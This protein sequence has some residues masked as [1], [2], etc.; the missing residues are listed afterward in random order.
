MKIAI[1]SVSDKG[2]VLAQCLLEKLKDDSTVM[3]VDHYH[4]NV[5]NVIRNVFNE[6]DAIIAVMASGIIIR[7]IAPFI[8]SKTS[9]P[10]ILNM[11][12]NG[13]FVVSML[14]GH[15]GGANKLTNKI[16]ELIGATP[17]ITTSTDVNNRLGI[18]TLAND[19]YFSIESYENILPINKAI[20]E[21]REVIFKLN[22]RSDFTFLYEYINNNTLEIDVFIKFSNEVP[23]DQINVIIDDKSLK[24][25]K[26]NLI[27]G[28]GCRRGKSKEEIE[29][30]ILDA[31]KTINL[32][33]NRVDQISSADVKK[34]EDG[35]LDLAESY[36][37]P[38]TFVESD[39]IKNFS[40]DDISESE[41]VKSKFG[42]GGVC[43]PSALLLAGE[44]SKLIYKKTAFN[45]VT[46][47]I[48]L[49]K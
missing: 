25:K 10:A 17:V 11:D 33:I 7:S 36:D 30:G 44:D 45:G 43:E 9:D 28:I 42:I 1:L 31:L 49:S 22:K 15:L 27:V 24:L 21:G 19:L 29:K 2:N 3:S 18:D 13:K 20:L 47:A 26:Q 35:L 40:F 48:A 32:S 6:Y 5:R 39:A 16:A 46:I 8:T 34:N 37:I 38:I 12:D 23:I 41:F 14:S 4:K